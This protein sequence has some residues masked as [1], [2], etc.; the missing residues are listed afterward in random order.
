MSTTASQRPAERA[1][2]LEQQLPRDPNSCSGCM[3]FV[4]AVAV[5]GL[6]LALV[7]LEAP[8][9]T[10][11]NVL[12]GMLRV[13]DA[14]ASPSPP[15]NSSSAFPTV[16]MSVRVRFLVAIAFVALVSSTL[17]YGIARR[18]LRAYPIEDQAIISTRTW[19]QLASQ[20]AALEPPMSPVSERLDQPSPGIVLIVEP[21]PPPLH[22]PTTDSNSKVEASPSGRFQDP[23][24]DCVICLSALG[25][26]C[27][28]CAAAEP[29]SPSCS[30]LVGTCGM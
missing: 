3:L 13:M 4:A 14:Y 9:D 5:L 22:L 29:P 12:A 8:D 21:P 30:P 27:P 25:S 7:V 23:Q 19:S 20:T 15:R 1:R 6:L 24:D 28:T 26:S 2:H 10:S 17:L 18:L 11:D 16:C